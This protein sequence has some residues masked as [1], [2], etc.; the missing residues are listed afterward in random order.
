MSRLAAYAANSEHSRGRRHADAPARR[1]VPPL[2]LV[3]QREQG[4]SLRLGDFLGVGQ[5]FDPGVPGTPGYFS[6]PCLRVARSSSVSTA[7]RVVASTT[8][9]PA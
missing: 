9:S 8:I 1:E 7:R 3:G 6:A 2:V 5:S 4:R